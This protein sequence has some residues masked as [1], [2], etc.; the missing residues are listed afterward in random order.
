MPRLALSCVCCDS[1]DLDRQSAILMPFVAQRAL[2]WTPC[3]VTADWGL[4]DIPPGHAL[5]LCSTL[6]CRECG[7]VF[8]DMR[9]DEQEMARLYADY[10]GAEYEALRDALEPG[11]AQRNRRLVA[12]DGHIAEVEAF[13]RP[14]LPERPAVL[15]WGGDTGQNTPMRLQA[16][17]HHVLDISGR[18]TLDGVQTVQEADLPRF[19]YDLLVL[20][21]VLEHVPEPG[22]LLA[23]IAS[24]MATSS[25]NARLYIEVPFEAL[26]R[27]AESDPG[28]WSRKRHWHEHINFFSRDSLE[29]LL[30]RH[31]LR[32]LAWTRIDLADGAV[33]LG[34][35]CRRD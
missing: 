20:G 6:H 14:W 27:S 24:V 2:N 19:R 34:A 7:L 16:S 10:R 31:G 22:Q 13:L 15:D 30:G 21:H 18:P 8:L 9:F 12:G 23:R 17:L 25:P 4:R 1:G 33:V 35:V 29:S 3:E 32:P 26:M 11:Y 5:A 28:A